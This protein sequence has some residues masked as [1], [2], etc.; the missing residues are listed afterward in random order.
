MDMVDLLDEVKEDLKEEQLKE[1]IKKRGPFILGLMTIFIIGAIL[2]L[3]WLDYQSNKSYKD[4]SEYLTATYKMR[5]YSPE[6]A[7]QKF[8]SL[9]NNGSTNYAAMA[10]IHVGSYYEYKKDYDKASTSFE[11]VV[12]G[13]YDKS[14]EDLA[15]FHSLKLASDNTDDL[16]A[17]ISSMEDYI[18]NDGIYKYSAQDILVALYIKSGNLQKAKDTINLIVTDINAPASIRERASSMATLTN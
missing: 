5:S 8:E 13:G 6:K 15:K 10:G 18:N 11:D 12:N 9:F 4:G 14:F 3:W 2:K 17:A 16:E 1:Y 7:I